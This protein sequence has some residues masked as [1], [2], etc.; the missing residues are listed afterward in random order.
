MNKWIYLSHPLN[1]K[2]PAYGGEDSLK[3]QRKKSIEKGDS[4]NTQHWSLSNHLG[5]HIDFPRHFWN[6]GKT[7]NDYPP[8]F[9]IFNFPFVIDISPVESDL[10]ILPRDVPFHDVPKNMDILIIKTGFSLLRGKDVYFKKNPG[11][12]P[13]MAVFL[14]EHFPKLRVFGF[15]SISLSS[16]S[17][18]E[19]GRE[20]HKMFLDHPRAILLL[21]DMDL[22]L[23][24]NS[25]KFKKIIISPLRVESTDGAPCTIFA[26]VTG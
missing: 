13:Q 8:E 11:F 20:A 24:N 16:F 21:E 6:D 19:I 25:F 14:R 10:M 26:E 22:S 12:T 18:K 9:W 2:T 1:S 4:C 3:I 7:I 5:T 15:D 17:H 23:V